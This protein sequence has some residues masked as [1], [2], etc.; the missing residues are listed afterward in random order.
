MSGSQEPWF[1]GLMREAGG[2]RIVAAGPNAARIN[3]EIE[4]YPVATMVVT[5][6]ALPSLNIGE[7]EIRR[8]L[9]ESVL[10]PAASSG[11][12]EEAAKTAR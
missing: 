1:F 7:V 3:R 11:Q 6:E 2:Y 10:G 8:W 12:T 4:H 9:P 5:R